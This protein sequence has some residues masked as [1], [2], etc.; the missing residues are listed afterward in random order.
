MKIE[1]ASGVLEL[2]GNGVAF[3]GED[4]I[5]ATRCSLIQVGDVRIND[6][7]I[8]DY[9]ENFLV[10]GR[11]IA[12][13]CARIKPSKAA[14]LVAVQREDGT[15]ERLDERFTKALAGSVIYNGLGSAV[16]GAIFVGPALAV[17]AALWNVGLPLLPIY[18][19]GSALLPLIL[20]FL[21]LKQRGQLMEIRDMRFPGPLDPHRKDKAVQE[22]ASTA[23]V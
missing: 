23:R 15:V 6:V 7:L 22:G 12:V 17:G 2:R 1:E 19:I 16:L 18:I 13:R 10:P 4:M 14:V 9:L 8:H 3:S 11:W 20:V 21:T 5:G